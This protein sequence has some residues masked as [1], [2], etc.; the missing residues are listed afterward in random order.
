MAA[1]AFTVW[2]VLAR[3]SP[4]PL[5]LPQ[6]ASAESLREVGSSQPAIVEG[7]RRHRRSRS[8]DSMTSLQP[9]RRP[10]HTTRPC[11]RVSADDAAGVR[12]GDIDWC[13]AEAT[14]RGDRYIG[15]KHA[16]DPQSIDGAQS[17]QHTTVQLNAMLCHPAGEW[18]RKDDLAGDMIRSEQIVGLQL[19]Q[20]CTYLIRCQTGRSADFRQAGRVPESAEQFDHLAP[21]QIL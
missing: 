7:G 17:V 2:Q 1:A 14:R 11:R 10:G 6:Q 19:R 9:R 20:M 16:A 15:L 5:P 3:R 4:G 13:L 8:T 18:I 21:G 12:R